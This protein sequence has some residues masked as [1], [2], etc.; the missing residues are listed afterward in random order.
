MNLDLSL[1][2]SGENLW[3]DL[4][5]NLKVW[6]LDKEPMIK[7]AFDMAY[8]A[9][10]GQFRKSG[11]DFFTHPAWVAKVVTQLGVGRRA[12]IAALLHDVIED[13]SITIDKIA[14]EFDDEVALLVDGLTDVKKLTKGIEVHETNIEVYR[15]FLFSSVDDVR[16]LIVR[17]VDKLH[18]ILTTKSLSI[19][20]Q[21]RNAERILGIYSPIAEY[22]GLHY[23]KRLLEDN[24]FKILH[25]KEAGELESWLS[26]LSHQEIKALATIRTEIESLLS[27]NRIND[28]KIEGRI[29]GLYSTYLKIK[30]KGK[31]KVK[32]RVGIRIITDTVANCYTILGLLHSKYKYLPDEFDDYISN[33]KPSGYRSLQTTLNWKNMLTLEV[34]IRTREMHEFNE[35]GPASHIAYKMS[36]DGADSGVG[37]EWVRELV[38]WQKGDE[39]I[40]NYR[41]KVLEK[42]IYV[43]TPKG[44]AIQMPA[45]STALDFAYRIH[46]EIGDHC[47]GAIINQKMGKINT[48]LKTGDLVEILTSKKAQRS[49][50]GLK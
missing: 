5:K 46:G 12:I 39:N 33:P 16:V 40:N 32:D 18:N 1:Y 30:K 20:K 38:K 37:Y 27:I 31:D 41:I 22:V 19:K 34:Q 15:K 48:K 47:I 9:H 35:F 6:D 45:G 3:L 50:K 10:K 24:A 7:K 42:Y 28:Y 23:F 14:D 49:K 17:T 44:D 4:E 2:S 8:E 13:T 29:K 21:K 43:F 36:K 11:E 26:E 25:P